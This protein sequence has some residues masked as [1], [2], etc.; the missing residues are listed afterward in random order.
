ME[1]IGT[2]AP[3][4]VNSGGSVILIWKDILGPGTS[5][6]HEEIIAGGDHIVRIREFD[7]N[8]TVIN[9]HCQPDEP[10]RELRLRLRAAAARWPTFLDGIGFFVSD[11]NICDPDE[12]KLNPRSQTF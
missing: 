6:E 11:F 3:G 9:L 2:F 1:K 4:N 10:S 7:C 8:C 5:I 12:G